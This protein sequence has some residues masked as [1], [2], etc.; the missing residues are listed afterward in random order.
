MAG[1][2]GIS[3]EE[4]IALLRSMEVPVRSHL[5]EL[6]DDQVSRIRAR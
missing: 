3:A 4:V 6:T 5:T 1:E 2:F